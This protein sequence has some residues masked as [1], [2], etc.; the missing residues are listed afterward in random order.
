MQCRPPDGDVFRGLSSGGTSSLLVVAGN[1]SRLS[2]TR[3]SRRT[4]WPGSTVGP[5]SWRSSPAGA[6][7]ARGLG[8]RLRHRRLPRCGGRDGRGDGGE[9]GGRLARSIDPARRRGVRLRLPGSP[10]VDETFERGRAVALGEFV[11]ETFPLV[12]HTPTAPASGFVSSGSSSS[13]MIC[14]SVEFPFATSPAAYRLTLAGLIEL[15]CEDPRRRW[16]RPRSFVAAE[17]ALGVA[18]ADLRYLRP[19]LCCCR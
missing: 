19:P 7:H 17:E 6:D 5:W 16:F 18:E 4:K 13:A 10:R 8:P 14:S 11:V 1:A 9:G 15:L 12:G 2:S 3:R